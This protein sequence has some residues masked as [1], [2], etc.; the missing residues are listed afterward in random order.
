MLDVADWS[1]STLQNSVATF[2]LGPQDPHGCVGTAFDRN[3]GAIN[4]VVPGSNQHTL[5][6]FYDAEFHPVCIAGDPQGQPLLS[7]IG[8]ATS[9]DGGLTWQKRGQVMPGLDEATLKFEA[10]TAWQIS[11]GTP[12]ED[13]GASG[14]S[15]VVREDNHQRFLYLYYA[16]RTPEH[17]T[18]GDARKDSVYVARA[19]LETDGMPGNWQQWNGTGWGAVGDLTVAAPI[20]SPPAGAAVALQ[21][22]VSWNTALHCWLMVFKT[23]VDFSVTTSNDG[24]TWTAPASLLAAL[25]DWTEFGFPTL[26]SP[27]SEDCHGGGRCGEDEGER[28]WAPGFGVSQQRTGSTGYLYW[29]S[30]ST[31]QTRYIGHRVAF[32]IA[33][34]LRPS[35]SRPTAG[36]R[37]AR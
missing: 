14:P 15:V 29:S 12:Q 9:T 22:H 8:L 20:V 28:L 3:Y 19:Q 10:V 6:A 5:L 16:D 35:S 7:S 2:G 24:V 21:P 18:Y 36:P 37:R 32:E 30:R 11:G 27:D 23:K 4:A 31:G 25:A 34:A 26:V 33:T 1:T 13:T 17:S